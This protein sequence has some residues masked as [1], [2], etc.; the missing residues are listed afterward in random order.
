M[1]VLEKGWNVSEKGCNWSEKRWYVSDK[2]DRGA[3]QL[4]KCVGKTRQC[5]CSQGLSENW[6]P[7]KKSCREKGAIGRKNS[8]MCRTK[9]IE[10]SGNLKNVSE[11]RDNVFCC[12]FWF[13][14]KLG[15]S[16][17]K[18]CR[19]KGQWTPLEKWSSRKKEQMCQKNGLLYCRTKGTSL[20]EKWSKA[21]KTPFR[22]SDKRDRLSKLQG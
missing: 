2:R 13:V 5:S 10:V 11:K 21:Q 14:G 7:Y 16:Q 17:K 3:W 1:N 4:K 9:G 15:T 22:L 19:K 20:S 12:F 8:G 18:S 6:E